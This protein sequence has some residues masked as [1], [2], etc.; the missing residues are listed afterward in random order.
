MGT[1]IDIANGTG[2]ERNH[3]TFDTQQAVL[4]EHTVAV[5]IVTDDIFTMGTRLSHIDCSDPS[6]IV[7]RIISGPWEALRTGDAMWDH[8]AALPGAGKGGKTALAI[9]NRLQV[10]FWNGDVQDAGWAIFDSPVMNLLPVGPLGG[11]SE[12]LLF[13][14]YNPSIGV[15]QCKAPLPNPESQDMVEVTLVQPTGASQSSDVPYAEYIKTGD[16]VVCVARA[17]LSGNRIDSLCLYPSTQ[18]LVTST[19]MQPSQYAT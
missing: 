11:Q 5:G 13:G 4:D 15:G 3:A 1:T 9:A 8:A 2:Y 16:G 17:K 12:G 7:Q 6:N 14:S 10:F 18:Q 19:D